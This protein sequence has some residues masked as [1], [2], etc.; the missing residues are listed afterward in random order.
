[1]EKPAQFDRSPSP[2]AFV[3]VTMAPASI[4]SATD[5]LSIPS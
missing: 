3:A 4:P 2:L 5:S 1:M